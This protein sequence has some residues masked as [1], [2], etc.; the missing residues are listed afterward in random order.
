M[1][2]V[3]RSLLFCLSVVLICSGCVDSGAEESVASEPVV[4]DTIEWVDLMPAGDLDALMNP[5]E[6]LNNIVD[7]SPQDNLQGGLNPQQG[8]IADQIAMQQYQQALVSM[9]VVP[10]FNQRHIRLAGFVVPVEFDDDQQIFSFFL[11]PYFGACLHMPPPPPNQ[12]IYGR[13]PEGFTIES[14]YQPYWVEGQIKTEIVENDT[15]TSAYV[16]DIAT[17]GIYQ[18]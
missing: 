18:D 2:P 9:Q 10:E 12:I 8:S 4:Y 7:G 6:A 14:L 13:F 16:M 5:P 17:V 11:V 15:A 3:F 1:T